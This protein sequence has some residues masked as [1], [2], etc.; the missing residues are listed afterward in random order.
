MSDQSQ[1]ARRPRTVRT[2][3][4]SFRKLLL[5]G[6]LALAAL[7]IAAHFL[8]KSSGSSEWQLAMDQDGVKVYAMKEPGSTFKTFRAVTRIKSTTDRAVAA[9]MDRGLAAC[10]EWNAGC[11]GEQTVEPWNEQE[12][13]FIHFYRVNPPA[14]LSPREFLLKAQFTPDPRNQSVFIQ[15]TA[16]PDKLPRND[17]CL[18]V[19]RMNNNWR[20][21]PAGEG[22]LDVEFMQDL[23][24]G[25]PYFIYNLA[26]PGFV[27][28]GLVMLPKMLAKEKYGRQRISFLDTTRTMH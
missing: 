9:M 28:D 14:P 20:F 11:V 4:K 3:L 1:T 18:R 13:Y 21:T 16:L 25:I 8:W 24:A 17:C 22:E 2:F 26:A 27:H 15:Y 12:L 10:A 7:L 23:D 6:S 5:G 19:T